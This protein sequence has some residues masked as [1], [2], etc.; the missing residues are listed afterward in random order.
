MQELAERHLIQRPDVDDALR[1]GA[2]VAR[3]AIARSG[4]A[5]EITRQIR[6]L[7][8]TDWLCISMA[9]GAQLGAFTEGWRL[10]LDL[11]LWDAD[12]SQRLSREELGVLL[13]LYDTYLALMY[14]MSRVGGLS[15]SEVTELRCTDLASNGRWFSRRGEQLQLPQQIHSVARAFLIEYVDGRADDSR[16]FLSRNGES[17]RPAGVRQRISAFC[18]RTALPQPNGMIAM[19]ASRETTFLTELRQLRTQ[20][21]A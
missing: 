10:T 19:Q 8:T 18:S 13:A 14:V 2:S 17:M 4:G 1:I 7:A 20:A 5:D 15:A 9:R 16:L 6:T 21:A 11:G 3:A 12:A